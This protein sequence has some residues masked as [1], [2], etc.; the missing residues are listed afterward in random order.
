MRVG[1]CCNREKCILEPVATVCRSA[2]NKQCD[3]PEYCD[4]KSEW[5]PADTHVLHGN[6]ALPEL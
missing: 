3:L 1:S 5:C 6:P 4:G 2:T